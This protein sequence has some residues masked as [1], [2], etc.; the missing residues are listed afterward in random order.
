M[1]GDGEY[2]IILK[3]D[4]FNVYD[5][6]YDG[7]IGNVYFDCYCLIGEKLWCIDLGYN[8]CVGVYYI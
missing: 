1:D 8:V 7:Y 5:N 4:F 6:V 2:E 3:W